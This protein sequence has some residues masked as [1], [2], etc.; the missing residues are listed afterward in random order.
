MEARVQSWLWVQATIRRLDHE[1]VPVALVRRGDPT[2]GAILVKLSHFPHGCV[3]L[4]QARTATGNPAW[5]RGT[6]PAPVPEPDA[7]AYIARALS[8]DPDAWVIEIEDPRQR[9]QLDAPIL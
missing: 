7:D 4:V 5:S 2:A 6:G 3:V 8:R 9:V 1:M